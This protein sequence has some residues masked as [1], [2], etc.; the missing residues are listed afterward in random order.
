MAAIR[1]LE[2]SLDHVLS[3]PEAEASSQV[4]ALSALLRS[5]IGISE[6]DSDA[7]GETDSD[8]EG[9]ALDGV[10]GDKRKLFVF[11]RGFM[12]A[13]SMLIIPSQKRCT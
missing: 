4:E 6:S 11:V 1:K 2:Q 3:A 8:T 7:D 10:T 12:V 13:P 9:M 5:H